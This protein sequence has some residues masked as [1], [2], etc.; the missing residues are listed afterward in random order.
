[1]LN[2]I[3]LVMSSGQLE[4]TQEADIPTGPNLAILVEAI[5]PAKAAP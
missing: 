1:M 5:G 2:F 3:Q 4:Q